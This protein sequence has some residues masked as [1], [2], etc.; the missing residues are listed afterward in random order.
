MNIQSKTGK[1]SK[2]AKGVG[3]KKRKALDYTWIDTLKDDEKDA[4]IKYYY[5]I[6]S[7]NNIDLILKILKK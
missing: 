2:K 5:R 3:R 7:E 6:F 1:A 4:V